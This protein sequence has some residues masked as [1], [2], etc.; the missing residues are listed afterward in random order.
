MQRTWQ[1]DCGQDLEQQ[2]NIYVE[3]RAAF[4]NLDPVKDRLILAVAALAMKA[5][6]FLKGRHTKKT[7][8][9]VKV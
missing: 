5:H 8:A 9:F 4:S 6:R 7:S 2:L 3:C 1:I